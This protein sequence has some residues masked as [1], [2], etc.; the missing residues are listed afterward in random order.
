MGNTKTAIPKRTKNEGR[1]QRETEREIE[2]SMLR[3]IETKKWGRVAYGKWEG[4]TKEGKGREGQVSSSQPG[5]SSVPP[6]T[7]RHTHTETE[8]WT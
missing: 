5:Q 4:K 8:T 1:V 6:P 7:Q 3:N 2:I